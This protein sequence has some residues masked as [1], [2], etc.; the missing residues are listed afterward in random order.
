MNHSLQV[1][2]SQAQHACNLL[3]NPGNFSCVYAVTAVLGH[4]VG[5]CCKKEQLLQ[6]RFVV[7][8]QQVMHDFN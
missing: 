7:Q 5:A 3:V 8:A 6:Q 2:P 1:H 4:S